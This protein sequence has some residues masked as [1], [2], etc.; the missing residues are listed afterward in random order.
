MTVEERAA[1]FS[2]LAIETVPPP[3]DMQ[4]NIVRLAQQ[5]IYLPNPLEGLLGAPNVK[6]V[7]GL[8]QQESGA[9]CRGDDEVRHVQAGTE[10]AGWDLLG[11]RRQF[12][13]QVA[14]KGGHETGRRRHGDAVV[15]G[16]EI[17][18][19]CPAPGTAGDTHAGA[20]NLRPR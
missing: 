3:P 14:Q 18:A 11:V 12:V 8:P 16:I 2:S 17:G 10:K 1:C 20:V 6:V 9:R 4:L 13:L 5:A 15:E 7:V 19:Q